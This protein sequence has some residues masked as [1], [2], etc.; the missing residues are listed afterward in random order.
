VAAIPI[1]WIA[2]RHGILDRPGSH[3]THHEPIP[4][5]GGL[6]IWLGF[7]VSFAVIAPDHLSIPALLTVILLV[8]LVYD[9]FGA[10]VGGPI[11]AL[12]LKTATP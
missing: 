6:A 10:E 4:Y 3:K 9:V 11:H 8:G 7:V 2:L 5:L 1:R 12:S